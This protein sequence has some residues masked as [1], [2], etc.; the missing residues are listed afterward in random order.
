M[1]PREWQMR[2]RDILDCI[3]KI[4]RYTNGMTFEGFRTSEI[5]IDAVRLPALA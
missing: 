5:T 1:P 4:G 2:V 3:A